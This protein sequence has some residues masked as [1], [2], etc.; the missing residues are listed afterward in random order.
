MHYAT[1]QCIIHI[2]IIQI[3]LE[4]NGFN[5]CFTFS[6]VSVFA[7]IKGSFNLVK[8]CNLGLK[9]NARFVFVTYTVKL[10]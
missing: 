9:V 1:K 7:T 6:I 3:L 5:H 2:H 8:I 4:Y 10:Q